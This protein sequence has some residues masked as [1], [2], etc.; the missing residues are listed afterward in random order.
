M[1]KVY[2]LAENSGVQSPR[3]FGLKVFTRVFGFIGLYL[4]IKI[5]SAYTLQ[6]L[7]HDVNKTTRY[8]AKDLDTNAKAKILALRLRPRPRSTRPKPRRPKPWR[9]KNYFIHNRM[10]KLHCPFTV[11]KFRVM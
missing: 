10:Y 11:V 8:K 4:T 7:I 2:C 1:K 9:P 3:V 5:R 6:S